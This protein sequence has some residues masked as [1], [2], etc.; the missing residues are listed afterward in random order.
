MNILFV[1]DRFGDWAGA[2]GNLRVVASAFARRGHAI[3]LLH[4]APTG[5]GESAWQ[6]L[7][8]E[9]HALADA[10]WAAALHDFHPD[11]VFLHSSPGTEATAALLA[12]GLPLVRMVHDHHLFCL[13][14][15]RYSIWSRRAC[16]RSLS[17]YCLIPCGG[18][19]NRQHDGSWSLELGRYLDRRRDLDLHRRF[20]RLVVASDYMRHELL[21]NGFA[22]DQIEVHPPVAPAVDRGVSRPRRDPRRIVFAGQIVRGKGVDVLLESLSLVRAPFECV[23]LGD[24]QH[25]AHCEELSRRLGLAGRVRFE[26]HVAPDDVAGWYRTA[27]LAVFSS[28]WPEPFGLAGLEALRHGVPVVAFDVGGVREWLEDGVSGLL[29]PWMDRDG[30]ARRVERLLTDDDLAHRLGEQG[31]RLAAE[32]FDFERYIEGLE[33]LFQRLVPTA[34][35]EVTR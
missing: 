13:R 26:G 32:R 4:G 8:P 10:G 18:I 25:R 27:T 31:R 1:H 24:G 19:L 3:G 14:G 22:E 20:A 29:A 7:F 16:T 12:S 30:F 15:C 28:V 9:R 11:A 17:P 6:E 33:A 34:T 5:R 35:C 2:E 21:R 23:I